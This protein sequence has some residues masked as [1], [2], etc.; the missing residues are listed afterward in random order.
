MPVGRVRGHVLF[1]R[2]LLIVLVCAG[3]IGF[4]PMI[5]YAIKTLFRDYGTALGL[6]GTFCTATGFVA[7]AFLFDTHHPP[8]RK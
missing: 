8:E 3:A 1:L 5:A 2:N 4:V 7:L 6:L